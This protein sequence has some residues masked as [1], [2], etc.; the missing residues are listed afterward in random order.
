MTSRRRQSAAIVSEELW[1]GSLSSEAHLQTSF[2]HCSLSPLTR[3]P[4]QLLQVDLLRVVMWIVGVWQVNQDCS[5]IRSICARIDHRGL[6][7]AKSAQLRVHDV[8]TIYHINICK[9]GVTGPHVLPVCIPISIFIYQRVAF[10]NNWLPCRCKINES[11]RC[12]V[13]ERK[14]DPEHGNADQFDVCCRFLSL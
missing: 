9:F 7:D 6:P 4:H 3:V 14:Q 10:P 1:C 5:G 12:H 2:T 13:R 8:S 11:R